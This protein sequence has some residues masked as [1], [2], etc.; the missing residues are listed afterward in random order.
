MA[1]KIAIG[2][3]RVSK[4]DKKE[5]INSLESQKTEILEFAIKKLGLKDDD[6]DWFV[7]DEA[8]S[9]YQDRANWEPFENKI[10]EACN[11]SNIAYFLS[12]SQE[13]FCRNARRS[14]QY[15]DKLRKAGIEIRFATGD[16]EDPTTVEGF[17]QEQVGEMNA[18]VT[19]MKISNDT[20]RGCKQNAQTR[21]VETG[22]AYQNG[23]SAPFWLMP[24][25]K[26]IGLDKYNKPITKTYW[27]E[28]KNIHSVT[29]NGK[30][31]T[32]TM[33]EW[34]QYLFVELRLK[35]SKSYK[36]IADFANSIKLPIARK[37]ALVRKN[38]LSTQAKYEMLYGTVIYNKRHYNNNYKK[39]AL[40]KE[41]EWIIVENGVPALLT[42]EQ[43][44][45][46]Q[47]MA[48]KKARRTDSTSS[49][50]KNDKLL[51]DMP[52][53]FYCASCGSKII[54]SG[55]H[56]V[57]SEY[58]SHGKQGCKASSFYVPSKWLDDKV[59]KEI[60]KLYLT[61]EVTKILY[62]KYVVAMNR[63]KV[64]DEQCHTEIKYLKNEIAK[65]EKLATNLM[66]S[67]N[68]GEIVGAALK[69]MS[70]KYNE[71]HEDIEKLKQSVAEVEAPKHY[72]I[73]TYDYFKALCKQ[74][75]K[76]LAHSLL[77]QRRAFVEKCIEAVILDPVK[78]EVHVKLDIFP[79]LNKNGDENKTKK[80]EVSA[81]DTSSEMVAGAGFEPTTFG[82]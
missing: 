74:N 65:K 25:T 62:D 2:Q 15:K 34:G 31:V 60:I 18:Q 19:S 32:K 75:S 61:D 36:E 39:G 33:W 30:L 29:I 46:L 52:D 67:I 35:Q 24:Y 6:I 58:N 70:D 51:V 42:K 53:K 26:E 73:L 22:Y 76:V 11:N 14:K 9:S 81:F 50:S 45:L 54:S 17:I 27:A 12:Y 49:N 1:I 37:S 4:G 79:F 28:N 40:K 44:D 8:R 72:R 20:L 63:Q 21:D 5:I 68:S 64:S 69:G 80:L 56:Y 77:P 41:E 71:L 55:S 7:E 38:T 59:Q 23:G 16:I 43:Y 66:N 47:L 82:L 57:C 3:C 48:N 13:R 78:K 10:D